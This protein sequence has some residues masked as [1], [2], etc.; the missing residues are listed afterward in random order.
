MFR[1]HLL[2]V[3]MALMAGV[4]TAQDANYAKENYNK[5]ETYISMRDGI[6]LFTA[7]YSPKD[8]SKDYPILFLRTPYSCRPYGEDMFRSKIGPNEF[9]MKDGYHIVYQDVRGRWMSE[10]VY[11]NMRAYIPNKSGDQTDE[12]SDTY[13]SIDWLIDNIPNNNGR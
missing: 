12:A 8:T 13:D 10:G 6:K 5:T 2:T 9:L 4:L 3:L 11:D 7:I 1:N